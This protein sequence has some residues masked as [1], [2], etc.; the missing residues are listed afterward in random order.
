MDLIVRR[1][2]LPGIQVT[3]S[4]NQGCWYPLIDSTLDQTR[5]AKFSQLIPP[6]CLSY[7]QLSEQNNDPDFPLLAQKTILSFLQAMVNAQI[8]TKSPALNLSKETPLQIWLESLTNL[9]TLIT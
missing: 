3:S 1:K 7:G 6:V 5:L 9:K 8:I 4:K 2:F